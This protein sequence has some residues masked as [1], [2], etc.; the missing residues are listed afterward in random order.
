MR[1][2]DA[3]ADEEAVVLTSREMDVMNVLW[4]LESG[5]VSEVMEELQDPLAY[6]TVL[7]I[8]RTL[9]KKG[10]VGHQ[11][12]GRAHRYFPRME[13]E[14]AREGAVRRLT[15]KLFSGSPELL[16]AHLLQ[17]RGISE[18]QLRKLR[19]LVD[20]RLEEDEK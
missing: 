6:T 17:E 7:T 11:T 15:R 19:K 16:M 3:G 9:E 12:E 4:R 1:L 8:L 13:R 2:V 10:H 20:N 5:T 14:E 18:A